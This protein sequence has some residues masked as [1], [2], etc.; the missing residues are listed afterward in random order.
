MDIMIGEVFDVGVAG[1][2]PEE[3]AD[4]AFVEDFSRSHQRE[5]LRQVKTQLHPKEAPG[6]GSRAVSAL[7]AMIED[8]L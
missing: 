7:D 2:K 5:A 8:S 4:D 3:F 1:E 6:P